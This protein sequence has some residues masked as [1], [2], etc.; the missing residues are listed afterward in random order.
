MSMHIRFLSF[1]GSHF[2]RSVF[3]RKPGDTDARL[4]IV[5]CDSGH[6][7]GNLIACARYH[8]Y[9]E[10]AKSKILNLVRG[11]EG[12]THVLFIIYLPRQA[13]TSSFVGYQGNPWISTH[14]D[15][16]RSPTE[17][18][19]T[20]YQAMEAP[21]SYLFYNRPESEDVREEK[22]Q[23]EGEE[24]PSLED[25]DKGKITEV[26]TGVDPEGVKEEQTSMEIDESEPSIYH[27]GLHSLTVQVL[28]QEPILCE[29][30]GTGYY[31]RLHYCIEAAAT[32]LQDFEKNKARSIDRVH[33]LVGLV[34][35]PP[36]G[37][38]CHSLHCY[39][40]ATEI[41]Y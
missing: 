26:S 31:Q 11:K 2:F 38:S 12:N 40:G 4:L 10:R 30:Y 22:M 27:P 1:Y 36:L 13:T 19:I 3:Q 39:V 32:K 5:Q 9:D 8:I 17:A 25:K 20:L 7:D 24:L 29:L 6:V 33:I 35:T 15:D 18:T 14:I 23:A 41:P 34:P 16:I 37:K 28:P 21:I